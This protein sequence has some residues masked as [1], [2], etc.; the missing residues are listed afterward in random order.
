MTQGPLFSDGCCMA[1]I[2]HHLQGKA[3]TLRGEL[4]PCGESLDPAGRAWTL[5]GELGPCGESLDPAEKAWTLRG[6]LVLAPG[7][8]G[9]IRLADPAGTQEGNRVNLIT[10]KYAESSSIATLLGAWACLVGLGDSACKEAWGQHDMRGC[11][12]QLPTGTHLGAW[13]SLVGLGVLQA[14]R[15]GVN[16]I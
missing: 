3:W 7:H 10:A 16:M 11:W 13:A 9:L 6:E 5:R 14:K 2:G 1:D 12:E 8:T 15:H 4:G